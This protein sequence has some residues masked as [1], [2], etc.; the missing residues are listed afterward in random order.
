MKTFKA[1]CSSLPGFEA[2]SGL[3]SGDIFT[4][5]ALFNQL[6][7]CLSI[8]PITLPVLVKG[9]TSR[10]R[11]S[12]FL[13]RPEVDRCKTLTCA[14]K[15]DQNDDDQD[16]SQD[17]AYLAKRPLARTSNHLEA[18]SGKKLRPLK[19]VQVDKNHNVTEVL[20]ATPKIAFSVTGATFSWP[21]SGPALT[22]INLKIDSGTLTIISGSAGSGKT[23]LILSLIDEMS[24]VSGR[25]DWFL[26]RR[27][28]LVTQKPW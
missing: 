27:I 10:N 28:A 8:F 15:A 26:D 18:V 23:S 17:E 12:E 19:E 14:S 24:L 6:S 5:L 25:V 11:L 2:D 20:G 4:T 1:N 22:D 7:V 13:A 3:S 9:L 16:E 21:T